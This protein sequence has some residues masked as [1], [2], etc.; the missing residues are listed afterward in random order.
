MGVPNT[1]NIEWGYRFDENCP[2]DVD[3][4]NEIAELMRNEGYETKEIEFR[5]TGM[6]YAYWKPVSCISQINKIAAI[7]E[8]GFEDSDCGDLYYYQWT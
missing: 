4:R 8:D 5:T 1:V 7:T 2:L 3:K 6:R